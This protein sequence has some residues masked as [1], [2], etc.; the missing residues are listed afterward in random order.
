MPQLEHLAMHAPATQEQLRLE[1]A[2]DIHDGR[3]VFVVGNFNDWCA[4]DARFQMTYLGAGRYIY[5]F[6]G[7]MPLPSPLEYKYTSGN[8]N[9]EE[10]DGFGCRIGNRTLGA[11]NGYIRDFVPRWRTNGLDY[12]PA[13]L[14]IAQTI[15]DFFEMP[16]LGK[17]RRV[18]ILLPHDYHSSNERY[19]VIYLQDG[20]NLFDEKA[21]Y[22]NWG[23]NKRLA[24]LAERGLGKVIVV[25]IDHGGS[26][27][28]IE[29][30]PSYENTRLGMG[31]GRNY[32]RFMCETLK[33]YIDQNFRT[34]AA[35]EHTAIGG[36]SMGGLISIYAGL[37]YPE[38]YSKMM[39]FSPALWVTS[40]IYFEAIHF[41]NPF[42]TK[43]YL[44]AGG[45]ESASMMPNVQRFKAAFDRRG[46]E[47]G[48]LEFKLSIDPN[49]Q[50]N[51]ARWGREFPHAVEWL[52][53]K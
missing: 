14:P 23:V 1:M 28:A 21:P 11:P 29:Y 43:I 4:D 33:P 41:V 8:W 27:R 40:K 38:V 20:Q 24:V 17:K 30:T 39:I 44:Y 45:N 35:R 26:E 3:P 53:Y 32:A 50:H 52:F 7:Q 12:N 25:A 19:P 9:N 2:T 51:E 48:N 34:L 46:M 6:D 13:F 15:T 47:S 10:L 49:G 22:G 42:D 37:M 36:S 18:S 5:V 31:F 16:Q